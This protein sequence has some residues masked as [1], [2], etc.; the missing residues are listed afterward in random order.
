MS[1]GQLVEMLRFQRAMQL[2]V[3]FATSTALSALPAIM[4]A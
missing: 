4:E 3:M 1:L 2:G